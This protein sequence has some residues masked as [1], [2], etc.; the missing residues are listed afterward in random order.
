MGASVK[1]HS[2]GQDYCVLYA[3]TN[4]RDVGNANKWVNNSTEIAEQA[5]S[6]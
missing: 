3:V 5:S 1:P 4:G 2:G 6:G